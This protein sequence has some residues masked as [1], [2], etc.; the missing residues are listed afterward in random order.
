MS[1]R[2]ATDERA[3]RDWHAEHGHELE[4]LDGPY[5]LP[6]IYPWITWCGA[7]VSPNLEFA[8][9]DASHALTSVRY[10]GS[11]E[12]CRACFEAMRLVIDKE[13]AP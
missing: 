6:R 3:T 11:V 5:A 12:P 2:H 13:L 9:L 4:V 1:A 10:D 7:Y 8:F